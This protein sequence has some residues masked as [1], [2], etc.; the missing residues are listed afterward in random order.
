MKGVIHLIQAPDRVLTPGSTIYLPNW[1]RVQPRLDLGIKSLKLIIEVKI[2]RNTSDFSKI[3]GEIGEDLGLYFKDTSLFDR[4]IV[5]IY[6]DCDKAQ[7]EKYDS[8][9][10]ALRRRDRVEDVIIIRRP[11][12]IPNRGLRGSQVSTDE[13]N[14]N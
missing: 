1:G 7:P 11:S 4:M 12:M 14:E 13:E 2:A 3:E 10:N 5:F 9:S 8:I 6:D